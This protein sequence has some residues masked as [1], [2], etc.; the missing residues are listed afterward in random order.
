MSASR[1]NLIK[2]DYAIKQSR[3]DVC[4]AWWFFWWYIPLLWGAEYFSFVSISFSGAGALFG[5]WA[6]FK[7]THY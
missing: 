5:I 6:G 1:Q 2:Y 3:V 4:W 7:L